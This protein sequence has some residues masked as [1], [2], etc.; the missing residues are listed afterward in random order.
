M[1]DE[2]KVRFVLVSRLP[3]YMTPVQVSTLAD[4]SWKI[5]TKQVMQFVN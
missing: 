2:N 1:V 4:E 5:K 3:F